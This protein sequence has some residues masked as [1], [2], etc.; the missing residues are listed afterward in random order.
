MSDFKHFLVCLDGSE[1]DEHLLKYSALVAENFGST[2]VTFIHV[3]EQ[4]LDNSNHKLMEASV[5]AYF[6]YEVETEVVI[7]QGTGAAQVLN[8]KGLRDID[9]LLMGIKPKTMSTGKNAARIVSGSLCSVMLVPSH[10]NFELTK[11]LVP[12]DFTDNSLKTIQRGLKIKEDLKAEIVLQHVYYVPTGY[13]STGK[14][15]DEFAE[16]MKKNKKSEYETF[17]KQ[18]GLDESQ[19]EMCY[20]L[21]ND[22]KPSDNIYE[23]A[24]EK[25]VDLIIIGSTSRSKI[26]SMLVSST[27]IGLIKY[28]ESIPCLIVRD[29]NESMGFFDALMKV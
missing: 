28:N 3:A 2:K 21:D 6:D 11:F 27:A 23:L 4:N 10:Q 18:N 9:L 15:Y 8:W 24:E 13:G 20:T 19:F 7:E 1:L 22:D 17:V 12:V 5:D 26:V 29:K 14:T 25:G 16:I